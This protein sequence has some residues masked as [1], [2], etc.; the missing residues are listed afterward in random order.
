MDIETIRTYCLEKKGVTES[1][2][3]HDE[4]LVFKVSEKIFML[5]SLD[6]IPLAFN[7]KTNPEWS[8]VLR[9]KYPQI[10]GAYHMNK[11][12]WNTV[13]VE[14]L[15]KSLLLELLDHSY[16]LVFS[17]LTKKQKEEVLSL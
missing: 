6:R 14:G 1:F 2:P 9:E 7:V 17:K 12:H 10:Y 8:E 16:D 4:T 3:F 15:P 11:K 13:V 5:I